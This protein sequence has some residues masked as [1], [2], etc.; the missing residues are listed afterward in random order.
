MAPNLAKAGHEVRAFDL[1]EEALSRAVEQAASAPDRRRGRART[2]TRSSPCCRPASMSP[3][4]IASQVFGKAPKSAI[5]IDCSTIDVATAQDRSRKRRRRR[6]TR[7]STR[8]CRA[9][10][11]RPRAGT[12][13]FMVG[14]SR[15]G[16]RE[17]AAD[18]RED[19]QGG[20]PRRRPGRGPGGEDLQQHAPR[21]DHGRDLR[22]VRAG[23]RSSGSTRRSS[24]TSRPR[25]RARA[26]R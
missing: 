18:P 8:R 24:S 21:R 6:A 4:S 17:G 10:S 5:L 12:L 13:T 26:G 25:R 11:P 9:A 3:R 23:R 7:W 19:G 14:G 15:R 16:V 2:P 20:D 1:S 22:G